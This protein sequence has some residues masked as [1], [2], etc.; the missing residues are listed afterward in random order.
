MKRRPTTMHAMCHCCGQDIE[1]HGAGRWHD[2]GGNRACVPYMD[3]ARGEVVTPPPYARHAPAA[4][5]PRAM[6][7]RE[8]AWS[9]R[10]E[11]QH[12]ASLEWLPAITGYGAALR[13]AREL[14]TRETQARARL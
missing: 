7:R 5:G 3:R 13:Y 8:A 2:R 6:L 14:L 12:P 1:H 11:V 9:Y 10:W 4:T